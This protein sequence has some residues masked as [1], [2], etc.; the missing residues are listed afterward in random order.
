MSYRV[1]TITITILRCHDNDSYRECT[2]WLW[3]TLNRTADNGRP[4]ILCINYPAD[5]IKYDR[6]MYYWEVYTSHI[7][8]ERLWLAPSVLAVPVLQGW[9]DMEYMCCPSDR[10]VRC[11]DMGRGHG[12]E[13]RS[14]LSG[15][16][17]LATSIMHWIEAAPKVT[18]HFGVQKFTPDCTTSLLNV[19]VCWFVGL[20][21]FPA[22]L[23]QYND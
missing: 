7:T 9:V 17:I 21:P 13:P 23:I 1:I 12:T 16:G 10:A 20:S 4:I 15:A 3:Y 18:G 11:L 6:D 5:W 8:D 19:V 2:E 22:L 14:P